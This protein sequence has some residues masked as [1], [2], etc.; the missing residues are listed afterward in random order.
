MQKCQKLNYKH[1]TEII[2]AVK[3]SCDLFW[4]VPINLIQKHN[5]REIDRRHMKTHS[6][7]FLKSNFYLDMTKTDKVCGLNQ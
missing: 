7:F 6:G 2:E 3:R 4:V 1:V 5:R